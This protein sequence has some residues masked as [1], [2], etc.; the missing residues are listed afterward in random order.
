MTVDQLYHKFRQVDFQRTLQL[1]KDRIEEL[2]KDFADAV[3]EA[4]YVLE[5][6]RR[7]DKIWPERPADA[8]EQYNELLRKRIFPDFMIVG[9]APLLRERGI[10]IEGN[11]CYQ[12]PPLVFE[13]VTRRPKK[14]D[15]E[16]VPEEGVFASSGS[17]LEFIRKRVKEFTKLMDRLEEE[18]Q[19]SM[20]QKRV[21]EPGGEVHRAVRKKRVDEPEREE[22]DNMRPRQGCKCSRMQVCCCF[23][24]LYLGFVVFVF[25]LLANYA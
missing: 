6:P 17:E 14:R 22:Q 21:G 11:D 8:R 12:L 7:T 10:E 23:T 13:R 25:F 16:D 5:G 19:D 15:A 4:L 20:R 3:V 9:L 2:K 24:I 1:K 18:E